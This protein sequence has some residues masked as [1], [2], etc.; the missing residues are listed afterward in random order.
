VHDSSRFSQ[1]AFRTHVASDGD[2]LTLRP[3]TFDQQLQLQVYQTELRPY[4][5]VLCGNSDLAQ[6]AVRNAFVAARQSLRPF[7]TP[8]GL[9]TCFKHILSAYCMRL[10]GRANSQLCPG[11]N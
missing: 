8:L 6:T 1:T 10:R 5:E 7:T 2:S 11:A 3:V 4:A 9:R